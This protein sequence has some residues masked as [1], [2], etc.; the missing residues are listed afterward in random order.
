MRIFEQKNVGMSPALRLGVI[1][2]IVCFVALFLVVREN[3]VSLSEAPLGWYRPEGFLLYISGDWL[4]VLFQSPRWLAAYKIILIVS[5]FCAL[6]GF[7]TKI[8][9]FISVVLYSFFL[10][11]IYAFTHYVHEGLLPIYLM[12]FLIWIPSGEGFSFD[13][14][15]RQEYARLRLDDRPTSTVGWAIFLLRSV[16]AF[17]F[18]QAAITQLYESGFSK[19]AILNMKRFVIQDNLGLAAP[20][21]KIGLSVIHWPDAAWLIFASLFLLSY[22]MYPLV[23]I[24]RQLRMIYPAVAMVLHTFFFLLHGVFYFDAIFLQLIFYDWD[25]ILGLQQLPEQDRRKSR[26][27]FSLS[28]KKKGA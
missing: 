9:L 25:R 20:D 24:F 5:L 26:S 21:I 17:S 13:Q 4:D 15:M 19:M 8:A 11:S 28:K 7:K 14:R 23:L 6:I 2:V 10:G 18:F 22:M 1:R 16:L 27:I 12:F 3:F